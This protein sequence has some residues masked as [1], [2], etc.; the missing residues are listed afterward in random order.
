MIVNYI[1]LV[2]VNDWETWMF[3]WKS[4]MYIW[5]TAT[6]KI[7]PV[8]DL[9]LNSSER[10]DIIQLR[11][12]HLALFSDVPTC[13]NVLE[14]DIDVG[15]AT[16][17]KQHPYRVNLVKCQLL[18]TEVQYTLDQGIAEPSSSPWSSPCLLVEKHDGSLRFCTDFRKVNAVTK[19]DSSS[20][21]RLEDCI[22]QVGSAS[23]VTKLDLL[24]GYWQVP[25]SQWDL[26]LCDSRSLLPL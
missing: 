1:I 12:Q 19:P 3:C 26:C 18:H 7:Y 8:A 2:K 6:G 15:Q 14:H 11:S 23:F 22:D 16:P 25:L 10:T 21:P 20:L 9:V 5:K 24:K 4:V 13:T 17:I